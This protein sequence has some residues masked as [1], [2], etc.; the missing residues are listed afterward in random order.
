MSERRAL[1]SSKERRIEVILSDGAHHYLEPSVLDV[2]LEK[3]QVEKFKRSSGWVT[4]GI[5]PVRVGNRRG[6]YL[7]Y[8]GIERRSGDVCWL[9]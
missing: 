5:S 7:P 6:S 3:N 1:L 4:V 8:H 2:L 9:S